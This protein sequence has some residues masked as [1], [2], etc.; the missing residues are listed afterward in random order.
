MNIDFYT[1]L[2]KILHCKIFGKRSII[3]ELGN[4]KLCDDDCQVWCI[5]TEGSTLL[6]FSGYNLN[7]G[8][9]SLKR[10]YV[11]PRHR[12]QGVYH[13]MLKAR[14]DTPH[15]IAKC[16]AT[17]SSRHELE[18]QGFVV[19]KKYKNYWKYEKSNIY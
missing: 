3:S 12:G 8:V 13:A 14:L 19:V 6:G 2:P 9:L 11:F 18:K 15:T 17:S 10:A 4:V 1:T 7:K 5:A 16:T